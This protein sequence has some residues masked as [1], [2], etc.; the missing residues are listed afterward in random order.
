MRVPSFAQFGTHPRFRFTDN[1]KNLGFAGANNKFFRDSDSEFVMPL[2]PDTVM[3]PDYL[4][5]LLIAFIDPLV[6]AAEG[7]MLKPEPLPDGLWILDGT[8]MTV[9]R[10]RRARERGN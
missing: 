2:N 10:A 6:A 3:P 8:G 1:K 5:R 9:S 4:S 7:K